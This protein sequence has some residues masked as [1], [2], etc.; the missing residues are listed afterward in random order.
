MQALDEARK[1]LGGKRG[2][3]GGI[4][5]IA[6]L[7]ERTPQAVSK[8]RKAGQVPPEQAAIIE[9]ATE[10]AGQKIT[11]QELSPKFPWPEAPANG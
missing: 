8:W 3:R 11:R 7:C 4:R 1:V 5:V 9:K 6:D 10:A 2:I